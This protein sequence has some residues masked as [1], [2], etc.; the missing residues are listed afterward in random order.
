MK[1]VEKILEDANKFY[2]IQEYQQA[3]NTC[4]YA[5][6]LEPFNNDIYIMK[7]KCFLKFVEP[8][9]D[10][11]NKIKAGDKIVW[12]NCRGIEYVYNDFCKI[13]DA[14]DS[15]D[16][17]Y[18]KIGNDKIEKCKYIIDLLK[19]N[20]DPS[21]PDVIERKTIEQVEKINEMLEVCKEFAKE[22]SE[23][24]I[25]TII[26]EVFLSHENKFD[27][28]VSFEFNSIPTMYFDIY[29]GAWKLGYI[30]EYTSK[31]GTTIYTTGNIYGQDDLYY[32]GESKVINEYGTNKANTGAYIK[33]EEY[34]FSLEKLYNALKS[35]YEYYAKRYEDG[36]KVKDKVN[37]F[38]KKSNLFTK[39]KK[40]KNLC[41]YL[42]I[43]Y[44]SNDIYFTEV[45][46]NSVLFRWGK[47]LIDYAGNTHKI[48]EIE[49]YIDE[50]K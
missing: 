27:Y 2:K 38:I 29:K 10:L 32:R 3:I 31:V 25:Y 23:I 34:D 49:K 5:L 50:Y 1:E 7:L 45:I 30:G 20:D 36:V 33:K 8:V 46:D 15:K 44:H 17:M 37:E 12:H 18:E 43:D 6:S 14:N 48:E 4:N 39:T 9:D 19:N 21:D 41:A 22:K 26:S 24:I 42:G 28:D 13:M 11:E 35:R 40:V 47:E 16:Y